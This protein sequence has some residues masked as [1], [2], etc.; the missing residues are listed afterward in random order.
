MPNYKSNLIVLGEQVAISS[1][2]EASNLTG[3]LPLVERCT[4][5]LLGSEA[6]N[7]LLYLFDLPAGCVIIPEL[8]TV[9]SA[10]P[11]TALV[12]DIGDATDPDRYADGIVLTAGGVVNFASTV[13][14][15]PPAAMVTPY[16]P[17][18]TSRVIM[19]FITATS[20]TPSV[21]LYFNIVYRIKG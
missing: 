13:A 6:A 4:Y 11:G 17:T 9:S 5:T 14:T 3:K 7:E 2:A 21:V 16:L 15:T 10:D 20:L 8:C 18:E 1:Q 19:K 12:V